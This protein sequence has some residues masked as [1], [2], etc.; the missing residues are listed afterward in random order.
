MLSNIV[1]SGHFI[2]LKYSLCLILIDIFRVKSTK[3]FFFIFYFQLYTWETF[4]LHVKIHAVEL[5]NS[6]TGLLARHL[7]FPYRTE[8][9]YNSL[10]AT[11]LVLD[12]LQNS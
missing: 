8:I 2:D 12:S 5:D 7:K 4:L 10:F 3:A 9:L 11:K 6:H 1:Q